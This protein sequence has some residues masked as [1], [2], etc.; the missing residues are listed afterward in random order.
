MACSNIHPKTKSPPNDW[1]AMFT[2]GAMF[3]IFSKFF[4]ALYLGHI[5]SKPNQ[6]KAFCDQRIELNLISSN[7]KCFGQV[8]KN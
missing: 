5:K 2:S 8:S 3:T 7:S 1:G 6:T 4:V